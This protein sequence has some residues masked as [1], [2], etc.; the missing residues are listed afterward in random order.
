MSTITCAAQ[1]MPG[2][3]AYELSTRYAPYAN[4]A[5]LLDIGQTATKTAA[6]VRSLYDRPLA[7]LHLALDPGHVGGIWAEWEWRN[8]RIS[9]EDYWVREGELVLEVALRIRTLLTN[10]GAEVTLLREDYRPINPMTFIDY[11]PLAV[12]EKMPPKD[13]S[14]KA[15]LDHALAVRNRAIH[16]A[17]V[18]G[19]IAERARLVN[20]VIQPDAL[21]SL[22]INAAPWPDEDAKELVD[23]D[24]AHVLIFGCLSESELA[25]PQQRV[26]IV[27]KLSNGSGAIEAHLGAALGSALIEAT[28]LPASDYKGRNAIRID[29][30]VPSLWARNLMLL[31]LV[32]CPTVLMEPYIANSQRSYARI[33]KALRAR[34]YHEP[35]A[36]DDILVEYADAVVTGVLHAYE[37]Y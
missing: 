18:R 24:H 1:M 35:L 3:I 15:Q 8:F 22:H 29:P 21:I 26:R 12:A 5:H 7:N 13:L 23:S 34:E 10:L 28:G 2:Q 31:R 37:R 32:D 19:E 16:M 33:Q 11:W 14:L 9:R 36:A 30:E 17:I 4:S 20:E 27:E 25:S 6:S